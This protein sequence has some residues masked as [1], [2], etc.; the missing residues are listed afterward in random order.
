MK[1]NIIMN[2]KNFNKLSF[3]FLLNNIQRYSISLVIY[4]SAILI[5]IFSTKKNKDNFKYFRYC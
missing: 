4:F 1:N 2:V 5:E 3:S